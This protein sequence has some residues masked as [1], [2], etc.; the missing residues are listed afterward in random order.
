MKSVKNIN[1]CFFCRPTR[2]LFFSRAVRSD[3]LNEREIISCQLYNKTCSNVQGIRRGSSVAYDPYTKQLFFGAPNGIYNYDPEKKTARLKAA[4]GLNIW[5]IFIT[6]NYFYYIEYPSK[7][8]YIGKGYDFRTAKSLID[9][10]VDVYF[11]SNDNTIYFTN[12]TGL[13]KVEEPTRPQTKILKMESDLHIR[14]IIQD[15]FNNV[16]FGA[17]EGIY[18]DT[19]RSIKKICNIDK[20]YGITMFNIVSSAAAHGTMIN[21]IMYSNEKHIYRLIC[22]Y[23]NRIKTINFGDF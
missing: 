6:K 5:D 7:T 20:I 17:F 19:G 9:G 14:Q 11:V 1:Q 8:L 2:E 16:Y 4:R 13:F 3:A 23:N 18:T 21:I 12:S 22:N 15:N 10:Q